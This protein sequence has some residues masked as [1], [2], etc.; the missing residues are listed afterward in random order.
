MGVYLVS[1]ELPETG[2]RGVLRD[3]LREEFQTARKQLRL[4]IRQTQENAWRRLVK[5]VDAD[6][7]S[8]GHRIVAKKISDKPTGAEAA[9]RERA[10]VEGLFPITPCPR[11]ADLL[12]WWNAGLALPGPPLSLEELN[13]AAV[14]L[15]G[16][17]YPGPDGI[18]NEVLSAVIR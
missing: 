17:K 6:P 16:G 8:L 7:W 3:H 12:I 11:W 2:R 15:P 10:I 5:S 18:I 4:V 1:S 14:R 9:G 13:M